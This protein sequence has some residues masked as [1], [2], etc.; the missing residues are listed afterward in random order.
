[1]PRSTKNIPL[2][3]VGK[4]KRTS[5]DDGKI[6]SRL[7]SVTVYGRFV[8]NEA[9]GKWTFENARIDKGPSTGITATFTFNGSSH[10]FTIT[11]NSQNIDLSEWSSGFC[12]PI[13]IIP[14]EN[15]I[16]R[17]DSVR[18]TYKEGK[19]SSEGIITIYRIENESF[20]ETIQPVVDYVLEIRPKA[21]RR[22][23]RA[24]GDITIP[25]TGSTAFT[26]QY[27]QKSNGESGSESA[28]TSAAT[29]YSTNRNA[30]TVG[31]GESGGTVTGK[32]AST[33]QSASTEIYATYKTKSSNRITV[34]VETLKTTKEYFLSGPTFINAI[35][36]ATLTLYC[37]IKD[38][39]GNVISTNR[40]TSGIDWSS[41][42]T[43]LATV[44]SNGQVT[45]HNTGETQQ[46][47]TISAVIEGQTSTFELALGPANYEYEIKITPE[48][49]TIR[50]TGQTQLTAI[51]YEF[52]NGIQHSTTD[53]TSAATW[54]SSNN[55]V[56]DVTGGK[57]IGHN[58]SATEDK[59]VNITAE[60]NG[61]N[62][63]KSVVTVQQ[64][65]V[66]DAFNFAKITF[67]YCTVDS[68]NDGGEV[69]NFTANTQ[70]ELSSDTDWISIYSDSAGTGNG[71]LNMAVSFW[72]TWQSEGKG[73]GD[74]REGHIIATY[75]SPGLSKKTKQITI[76]QWVENRTYVFRV[77]GPQRIY[78]E[79]VESL[80][81]IA[82]THYDYPGATQDAGIKDNM[83]FENTN[84][85][86][87]NEAILVQQDGKIIGKNN[88]EEDVQVTITATYTG[89]FGGVGTDYPSRVSCAITITS[90]AKGSVKPPELEVNI[91][92]TIFDGTGGTATIIINST[93]S[94][95]IKY[96]EAIWEDDTQTNE[97]YWRNNTSW[98]NVSG[99]AG[100]GN[101]SA[102]ISIPEYLAGPNV[103][104]PRKIRIPIEADST[105][106][107]KKTVYITI[108]QY[109]KEDVNYVFT[110]S[111]AGSS[112]NS[113]SLVALQSFNSVGTFALY[114]D[115]NLVKQIECPRDFRYE[116]QNETLLPAT[117]V[118]GNNPPKNTVEFRGLNTSTASTA[119]TSAK[120]QYLG[121]M[122][123]T[124][125]NIGKYENGN[126]QF[127]Y[128]I[129]NLATSSP[130]LLHQQ[131]RELKTFFVTFLD[132]KVISIEDITDD[133][134]FTASADSTTSEC[135]R[136]VEEKYVMGDNT[137]S[138]SKYGYVK[139]RYVR[140][141]KT[142]SGVL[143]YF[144]VYPLNQFN[145]EHKLIAGF[146]KK[147]PDR[148]EIVPQSKVNVSATGS[149]KLVAGYRD[150]LSSTSSPYF[151]NVWQSP[152][153]LETITYDNPDTFN[154]PTTLDY[155]NGITWT[156][157]NHAILNVKT[158]GTAVA[159][160]NGIG[161]VQEVVNVTANY[162]DVVP[163]SI[164][165][166]VNERG[167]Y[168]IKEAKISVSGNDSLTVGETRQ[169]S[170]KITVVDLNDFTAYGQERTID[171]TSA[172][173]WSS[174]APDFL[175]IIPGTN[176][177]YATRDIPIS[178]WFQTKSIITGTYDGYSTELVL[179]VTEAHRPENKDMIEIFLPD[180]VVQS[181]GPARAK[182]IK[183]VSN[184][185]TAEATDISSQVQWSIE[186]YR[187]ETPIE[188]YARIDSQGYVYGKIASGSSKTALIKAQFG[189]EQASQVITITNPWGKTDDQAPC[190]RLN[191]IEVTPSAATIEN[192]G[193]LT[194]NAKYFS[195]TLD[196]TTLN[197]IEH[198]NDVSTS[199]DCKWITSDKNIATVEVEDGI[200]KVRST[201]FDA[202]DKPVTISALY[203]D[204]YLASTN[205][206][207]KK[208]EDMPSDYN[209]PG[210][211][212]HGRGYTM[213]PGRNLWVLTGS[214]VTLRTQLDPT[215]NY[216]TKWSKNF[217]GIWKVHPQDGDT[218]V[219]I[220]C[221]T[222][223]QS[224]V[225]LQLWSGGTKIYDEFFRVNFVSSMEKELHLWV[226][227]SGF[228]GPREDGYAMRANDERQYV[229][230]LVNY[231]DV[232]AITPVTSC[233]EFCNWSY[234][235]RLNPPGPI[236][237]ITIGNGE[238]Q[239]SP[240]GFVVSNNRYRSRETLDIVATYTNGSTTLTGTSK[241]NVL[242]GTGTSVVVTYALELCAD[243]STLRS[244]D[245]TNIHA[246]QRRYE[247]GLLVQTTD[248]TSSSQ[249]ASYQNDVLSIN[250]GVV[251]AH[252]STQQDEN[253]VVAGLYSFM[254]TYSSGTQQT[255]TGTTIISVEAA[256]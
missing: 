12:S 204:T 105:S 215:Y 23:T 18:R 168:L 57:V 67:N 59:K 68:P 78:Y 73:S 143:C 188:K 39:L 43:N 8:Q 54:T 211:P 87:N 207:V 92:R 198:I 69:I 33:V 28:V 229:A 237:P 14:M 11:T 151:A 183:I 119:Q 135:L 165:V 251:S 19:A 38:E 20:S 193:E 110:T 132:R 82:L 178:T 17:N 227:P 254:D 36:T 203:D 158:D 44:D 129:Y 37:R 22:R 206:I 250:N 159:N 130:Y 191:H 247:N 35:G 25:A 236:P 140:E 15:G 173:T 123:G 99:G 180:N 65:P 104:K 124:V 47:V 118:Y 61:T 225:N 148:T 145:V 218:A 75:G 45:G 88:S 216:T 126:P 56:A 209:N 64:A 13:A 84:W 253:V 136:I 164:N 1:M 248:V 152:I 32:N 241:L 244:V 7:E 196:E 245:E 3:S 122:D 102:R 149:I 150:I 161:S 133:C 100:S 171:V 30:A 210:E 213:E 83:V 139:V 170:M 42:D 114:G 10:T 156:S 76:T 185:I 201:S 77:S 162:S 181:P 252:N 74:K 24:A 167:N 103:T 112:N 63:K 80:T 91:D 34:N 228:T 235:R 219:T 41:S 175:K 157:S 231:L 94:W 141:G 226:F 113:V 223:G 189:G 66:A 169:L 144:N 89:D 93:G 71:Q 202:E 111:L 177:V 154:P 232:I 128:G 166:A 230:Q 117:L 48:N 31:Q 172:A 186:N 127:N 120:T 106:G 197:F 256:P 72:T 70:W 29:W 2:R 153:R 249:F 86:S 142:Y 52:I 208:C 26:A 134:T 58:E 212:Y 125:F 16:A 138:D 55:E 240:K 137:S 101:G 195:Y 85:Y 53:V 200:A 194:I 255:L 95:E 60:Y 242:S 233:T 116:S 182:A 220:Q 79:A 147:F 187:E 21:T 222:T 163:A 205:F 4:S 5:C 46:N 51:C 160:N 217:I 174:S 224:V 246:F 27:V 121:Y 239:L 107:G 62:S 96:P 98:V 40:V 109:P 234:N 155:S 243:T 238:S 81:P 6:V 179:E 192:D 49:V 108:I 97:G 190:C 221:D 131:R 146:A 176:I 115:D 184:G 90:I 199:N 214:E 9:T 50:Y